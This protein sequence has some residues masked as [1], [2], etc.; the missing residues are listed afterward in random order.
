MNS[1]DLDNSLIKN[2]KENDNKNTNIIDENSWIKQ[3]KSKKSTQLNAQDL[4]QIIRIHSIKKNNELKNG[5]KN[6]NSLIIDRGN[7]KSL[8]IPQNTNE[9][10]KSVNSE[11][12]KNIKEEESDNSS[13]I[14]SERN[15]ESDSQNENKNEHIYNNNKENVKKYNNKKKNSKIKEIKEEISEENKD[16][17]NSKHNKIPKIKKK[18][19]NFTNKILST[20]EKFQMLRQSYLKIPNF[21]ISK[22]NLKKKNNNNINNSNENI[23]KKILITPMINSD[24]PELELLTHNPEN[25]PINPF[26][27]KCALLS[28]KGP[29]SARY[30]IDNNINDDDNNN[31]KKDCKTFRKSTFGYLN[32]MNKSSSENNIFK[33]HYGNSTF[34]IIAPYTYRMDNITNEMF[35]IEKN[36]KNTFKHKKSKSSYNIIMPVNYDNKNSNFNNFIRNIDNNTN[37]IIHDY[38]SNNSNLLKSNDSHIFSFSD[39][40]SLYS[41]RLPKKNLFK[42]IINNKNI[43][44]EYL[45]SNLLNVM[46]INIKDKGKINNK[47]KKSNSIS[48]SSINCFSPSNNISQEIF[49][50]KVN[51]IKNFLKSGKFNNGKINNYKSINNKE[52]FYKYSDNK[53]TK[54]I[55]PPNAFDSKDLLYFK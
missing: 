31:E 33:Q 21:I 10:N 46:N 55:F 23:E 42:K 32:E 24:N 45:I 16:E 44:K 3:V 8:L 20:E 49:N 17:F 14:I 53:F 37:K 36:Q 22:K 50:I 2:Q 47:H 43:N 51:K 35:N 11:L 5:K 19:N 30:Y 28:D 41:Y 40:R 38:S 12:I 26:S 25:R 1:N 52:I 15:N 34:N 6:R 27:I 4:S 29:L 7:L 48:L 9:S 54:Q 18:N 13:N 39:K